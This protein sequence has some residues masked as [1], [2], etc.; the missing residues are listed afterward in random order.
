MVHEAVDKVSVTEVVTVQVDWL[1]RA[2]IRVSVERL[3]E[4]N[5][6]SV[7]LTVG[8]VPSVNSL[9]IVVRFRRSLHV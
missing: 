8:S 9:A 4:E 1:Q 3:K 7:V 2:V 5:A 6:E